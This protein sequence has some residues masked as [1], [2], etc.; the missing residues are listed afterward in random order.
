MLRQTLLALHPL[1]SPLLPHSPLR[2]KRCT[3]GGINIRW[4]YDTVSDERNVSRPAHRCGRFRGEIV[5]G[6]GAFPD[7]GRAMG[8][9]VAGNARIRTFHSKPWLGETLLVCRMLDERS[10]GALPCRPPPLAKDP[11]SSNAYW[12]IRA[13]GPQSSRAVQKLSAG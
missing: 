6:S 2:H 13:R 4:S 9:S 11:S 12:R 10:A 8:R 7:R 1:S 5:T 3:A